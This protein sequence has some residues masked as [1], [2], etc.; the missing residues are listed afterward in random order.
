[1]VLVID[2]E[3]ISNVKYS[4]KG[5]ILCDRGQLGRIGRATVTGAGADALWTLLPG[6]P[7]RA[8][9]TFTTPSADR[10]LLLPKI[11]RY[12]INLAEQG[13]TIYIKNNTVRPNPFNPYQSP[14][15]GTSPTLFIRNAGGLLPDPT[16]AA[17]SQTDNPGGAPPTSIALR[18]GESALFTALAFDDA[19][20]AGTLDQWYVIGPLGSGAALRDTM[21]PVAA[22]LQDAYN[23]SPGGATPE[24]I[25]ND[26][27]LN[28]GLVL[29]DSLV[30]PVTGDLFT[31][32]DGAGNPRFGVSS[33]AMYGL[34]ATAPTTLDAFVFGNGASTTAADTFI[35]GRGTTTAPGTFV[36]TDASAL[37]PIVNASSNTLTKRFLSGELLTAGNNIPG[38]SDTDAHVART[39]AKVTTSNAAP[40]TATPVLT[41]AANEGA[42][43]ELRVAAHTNATATTTPYTN[44]YWFQAFASNDAAGTTVTLST[45]TPL[46]AQEQVFLGFAPVT[47][48]T[49]A[50]VVSLSLNQASAGSLAGVG[51]DL[52]WLVSSVIT[53][54]LE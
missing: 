12:N 30:T 41:L 5:D 6:R 54:Y 47:L 27:V 3:P 53:R 14:P 1:M 36:I 21:P 50:G 10:D 4:I 24:I 46:N 31:V 29:R 26:T 25:L 35:L 23:N 2:S 19:D 33:Q 9:I 17:W 8:F 49:A 38:T 32:Q 42:W 40:A 45:A 39:F 22:S 18:P 28:Q 44:V 16:V 15:A 48:T 37:T 11:G 52:T 43:L 34:A 20:G 7:H 13:H 51:H